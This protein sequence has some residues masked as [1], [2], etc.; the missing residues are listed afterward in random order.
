MNDI[1]KAGIALAA[2][3]GSAVVA[4]VALPDDNLMEKT[5]NIQKTSDRKLME[6]AISGDVEAFKQ[7]LTE[8]ADIN[9]QDPET[10]KTVLMAA[11]SNNA[12]ILHQG[13]ACE[14]VKMALETGKVDLTLKDSKNLSLEDYV[15]STISDLERMSSVYVTPKFYA[16][17]RATKSLSKRWKEILKNIHEMPQNKKEVNTSINKTNFH[18]FSQARKIGR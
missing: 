3:L 16:A 2:L 15:V 9:Y 17:G 11:I 12:F 13:N 8:K 18:A 14:I 5:V 6:A 4:K 7:A 1:K 10:G